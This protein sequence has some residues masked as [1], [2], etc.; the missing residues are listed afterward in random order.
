MEEILWG[1]FAMRSP[2]KSTTSWLD[3][4]FHM[5]SQASTMKE[6]VAGSIR[7][8]RTSGTG[9]IICSVRGSDLFFLYAWSP[10]KGI[11][12]ILFIPYKTQGTEYPPHIHNNTKLSNTNFELCSAQL[13]VMNYSWKFRAEYLKHHRQTTRIPPLSHARIMYTRRLL[14]STQG[15]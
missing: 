13:K 7:N 6:S 14:R 9:E 15:I 10:V 11:E 5:P 2:T 3:I 8:V 12:A 4:E 1:D